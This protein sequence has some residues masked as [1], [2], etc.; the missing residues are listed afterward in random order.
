MRINRLSVALAITAQVNSALSWLIAQPWADRQ[1]IS[2]LGFSLG[3]L[4]APAIEDVGEY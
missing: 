2:L 1:R 3:A 4:A